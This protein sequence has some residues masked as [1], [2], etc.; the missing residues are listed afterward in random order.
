MKK[1]ETLLE[2]KTVQRPIVNKSE[3]R[4]HGMLRACGAILLYLW[5][6]IAAFV[7]AI[8]GNAQPSGG[9]IGPAMLL[10]WLL[11]MVLLSNTIGG[12]NSPKASRRTLRKFL[13]R[14]RDESGCELWNI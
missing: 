9:M 10:S 8:G 1:R 5:Q 13:R 3:T 4:T 2:R 7:P 12:V 14:V 6:V 11:P